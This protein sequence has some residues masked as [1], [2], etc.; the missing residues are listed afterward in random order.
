MKTISGIGFQP[1]IRLTTQAGSLC[2]FSKL[3]SADR[4]RTPLQHG[5]AN[6]D[7]E[8]SEI[9]DQQLK[10]AWEIQIQCPIYFI[11]V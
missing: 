2:H 11:G 7:S 8:K 6:G 1:M 10:T 5:L 4:L 9:L 3:T